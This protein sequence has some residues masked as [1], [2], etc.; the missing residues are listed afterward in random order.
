MEQL[1]ERLKLIL[2]TQLLAPTLKEL[3]EQLGYRGRM[4]LYRVKTGEASEAALKR[5]VAKL[6]DVMN[7]GEDAI[8]EMSNVVADT[9]HMIRLVRSGYDMRRE[10]AAYEVVKALISRDYS[11]FPAEFKENELKEI[12]LLESE[13]DKDYYY[14]VLA[15]FYIVAGRKNFYVKGMSHAQRCERL[16]AEVGERL[17][18]LYPENGL[19]ANFVHIYSTSNLL[20]MERQNLWLLVKSL[21]ALF[22]FYGDPVGCHGEGNMR[23]L[24]GVGERAYWR[25]GERG[26][27][28]IFMTL[29]RHVRDGEYFEAFEIDE[30]KLK[31]INTHAIKILSDSVF[32]IRQKETGNT[33]LGAYEWDGTR[34]EMFLQPPVE[35]PSSAR[36]CVWRKKELT[37]SMRLR[38]LNKRISDEVLESEILRSEGLE[39]IAGYGVKDVEVTR[40]AL[41][42]H[43]DNGTRYRIGMSEAKFLRE[44]TPHETVK[45]YRQVKDGRIFAYWT[46]LLHC[47]ELDISAGE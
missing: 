24:P 31:A 45:I 27:G 28:R 32:A 25:E 37:S 3:A 1:A 21:A 47:I 9:S 16:M 8:I 7:M 38:E 2:S 20:A 46:D 43:L 17:M 10:D 39:E 35:N 18:E 15:Y 29:K 36:S 11:M 22:R 5:L 42:L 41:T 40:E 30:E 13:G 4:T 19:G 33:E 44:L 6:E 34:F 12:H 26:V 23:G 14:T